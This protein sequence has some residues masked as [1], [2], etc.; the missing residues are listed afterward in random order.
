MSL[1]CKPGDLAVIVRESP[2]ANGVMGMIVE[3]LSLAP[4]E[5]FRLPCGFWNAAA[6]PGYPSW[7]CKFQN[8]ITVR[9]ESGEL[10]RAIFASVRDLALRPIR[11]AD[12]EDE[13]L[14]WAGKPEEVAA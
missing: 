14:A 1:N 2:F 4:N 12:G 3:V 6:A 13:T 8:P 5:I 7:V 11:P 9:L 10:R